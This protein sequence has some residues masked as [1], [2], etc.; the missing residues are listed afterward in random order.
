MGKA[1][2]RLE[3]SAGGVVYHV[4]PQ[5]EPEVVL[6]RAR[7]D[8]RWAL[9]KGWVEKDE[10][11]QDAALREVREETGITAEVVEPLDRIEY[12]FRTRQGSTPILV[13]KYVDFFLMAAVEGDLA[14]QDHEVEEARW[15]SL[16]EAVEVAAFKSERQV[17]VQARDR[18]RPGSTSSPHSGNAES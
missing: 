4:G 7:G 14:D 15:F 8:E 2:T 5:G 13:H 17:L 3:T 1:R 9:P 18:L 10:A 11:S 12:W 16:D 6:I